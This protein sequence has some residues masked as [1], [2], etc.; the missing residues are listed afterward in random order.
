MVPVELVVDVE[1]GHNT[2]N[3]Y[4]TRKAGEHK[5]T[6]SILGEKLNNDRE[7]ICVVMTMV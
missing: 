1:V 6:G 5:G 7:P 4:E 2:G 3:K